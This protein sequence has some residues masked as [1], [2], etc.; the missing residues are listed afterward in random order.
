MASNA[1]IGQKEDKMGKDN[2]V[3]SPNGGLVQVVDECK[4]Y[5]VYQAE[6]IVCSQIHELA[7]Q[8][9]FEYTGYPNIQ[10]QFTDNM[11]DEQIDIAEAQLQQELMEKLEIKVKWLKAIHKLDND[12]RVDAIIAKDGWFW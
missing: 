8:I 10:T 5:N 7:G 12:T 1:K 3:W 6:S 9:G 4:T 2:V 11:T